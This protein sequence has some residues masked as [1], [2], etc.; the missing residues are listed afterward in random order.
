MLRGNIYIE[1]FNND[2]EFM[3]DNSFYSDENA[4]I[5]ALEALSIDNSNTFTIT[6][7]ESLKMCVNSEKK[8]KYNYISCE[9]VLNNEDIDSFI[10]HNVNSDNFQL[11]IL[12]NFDDLSEDFEYEFNLWYE[13]HNKMI[14]LLSYGNDFDVRLEELPHK[15]LRFSFTNLSGKLSYALLSDC[16]ILDKK[17]NKILIRVNKLTFIKCLN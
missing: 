11:E 2:D 6:P 13:H 7:L 8:D 17:G 16:V 9:C 10:Y 14:K 5:K 3:V 4:Y 1:S 15:D 12:L